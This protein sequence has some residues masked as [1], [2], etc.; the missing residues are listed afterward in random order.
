LDLQC[1]ILPTMQ[2][3][4]NLEPLKGIEPFRERL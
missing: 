4:Q 2:M 3:P 1:T